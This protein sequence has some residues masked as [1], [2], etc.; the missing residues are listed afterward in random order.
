MGDL[1]LP[2]KRTEAIALGLPRYFTGKPCKH[3]HI[4]ERRANDGKCVECSRRQRPEYKA[5]QRER[6]RLRWK[7]DPAYRQRILE[8]NRRRWAN[9]RRSLAVRL[10][11]CGQPAAGRSPRCPDCIRKRKAETTRAA[12]ERYLADPEKRARERASGR[13]RNRKKRADNPEKA[14][15]IERA[16]RAKDRERVNAR[17][18]AYYHANKEKNLAYGRR[19]RAIYRAAI[20]LF[21]ELAEIEE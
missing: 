10:C 19:V 3:G 12:R 15:A 14:R 11:A 4:R 5:R 16:Y 13:E 9:E 21:P 18:R 6:Q 7:N 2:G 1:P 17:Q 20:K 8:S